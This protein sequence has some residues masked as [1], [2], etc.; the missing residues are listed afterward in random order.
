VLVDDG[1]G[2]CALPVGSFEKVDEVDAE[3]VFRLPDLPLLPTALA[4]EVLTESAD[5]VGH[6]LVGCRACQEATDP[7]DAVRRRLLLDEPRLQE[8][9]A[10]L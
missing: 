2:Q 7:A 6:G 3:G 10:E 9:L 1:A 8:K 5:L 4:L